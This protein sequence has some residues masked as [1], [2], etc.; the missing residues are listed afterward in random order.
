MNIRGSTIEIGAFE[1]KNR[2][3]E[4]LRLVE[5]GRSVVITRHGRAVARLVPAEDDAMSDLSALGSA[6]RVL[7][8][9]VEGTVDV[10]SLVEEGRRT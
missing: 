7:R 10:R 4:L 2:L 1:A 9:K 3:S 5:G 6:L 8:D